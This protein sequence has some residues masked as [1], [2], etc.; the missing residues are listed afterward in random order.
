MEFTWPSSIVS[1]PTQAPSNLVT[2]QMQNNFRTHLRTALNTQQSQKECYFFNNWLVSY[3]H[4]CFHVLFSISIY[5]HTG[6]AQGWSRKLINSFRKKH[7]QT[8]PHCLSISKMFET[9]TQSRN[10]QNNTSHAS[11]FFVDTWHCP[12][13][14]PQIMERGKPPFLERFTLLQQLTACPLILVLGRLLSFWRAH[15]Q[16]FHVYK[17]KGGQPSTTPTP[18]HRFQPAS[19]QFHI[20]ELESKRN[21]PKH[22]N[23]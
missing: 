22:C 13:K 20:V 17:E 12:F 16:G 7:V 14:N 9:T 11:S 8:K 5:M 10:M 6:M 23:W 18:L 4:C 15:F 19:P 3:T 21:H 2:K 1:T